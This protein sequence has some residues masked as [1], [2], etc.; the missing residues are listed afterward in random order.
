MFLVDSLVPE[1]ADII[2]PNLTERFV[3]TASPRK[4]VAAQRLVIGTIDA[5]PNPRI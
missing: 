1:S 5:G 4:K 3:R 2:Y